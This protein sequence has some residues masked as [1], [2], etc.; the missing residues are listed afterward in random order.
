M[1][2]KPSEHS[3]RVYIGRGLML[4]MLPL[5]IIIVIVRLIYILITKWRVL[6]DIINQIR[7]DR[8]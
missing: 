4:A 2:S 3:L 7:K 8:G 1:I 5:A 6:V